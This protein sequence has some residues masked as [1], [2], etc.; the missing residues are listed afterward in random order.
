MLNIYDNMLIYAIIWYYMLI[1][2]NILIH[3]W[4]NHGG[5]GGWRGRARVVKFWKII[6]GY[7]DSIG[8]LV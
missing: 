5:G 7:I 2:V 4:R 3:I 1:Y 6:T 8:G